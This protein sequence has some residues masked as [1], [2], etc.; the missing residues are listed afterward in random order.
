MKSQPW[1]KETWIFPG[2]TAGK[3]GC[4]L[5]YVPFLP[6]HVSLSQIFWIASEGKEKKQ[7]STRTGFWWSCPVRVRVRHNSECVSTL[8]P[9]LSVIREQSLLLGMG[10]TEGENYCEGTWML[11]LRS[12]QGKNTCLT[13][14]SVGLM[15]GKTSHSKN[16]LLSKQESWNQAGTRKWLQMSQ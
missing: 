1:W 8:Q 16:F 15:R 10:K 13:T 2:T 9:W 7:V 6:S 14:L 4:S 5:S 12:F 3:K 11:M